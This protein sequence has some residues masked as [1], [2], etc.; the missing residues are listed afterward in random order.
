MARR[1]NTSLLAILKIRGRLFCILNAFTAVITA[2]FAR[3]LAVYIKFMS[4]QAVAIG[5]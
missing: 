1:R 5:Y 4:Q 2:H 3:R